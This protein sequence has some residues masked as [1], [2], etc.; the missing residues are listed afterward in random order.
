MM[1]RKDYVATAEILKT[2]AGSI[3]EIAFE[4]LVNDFSNMFSSDNTKFNAITF[5]IACGL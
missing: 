3:D 4:D 1:T 5:K 2:Y